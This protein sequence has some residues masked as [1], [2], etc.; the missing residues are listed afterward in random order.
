M[1]GMHGPTAMSSWQHLQQKIC[2]LNCHAPGIHVGV[3]NS[4][5]IDELDYSDDE[6]VIEEDEQERAYKLMTRRI[7]RQQEKDKLARYA[8]I[9]PAH[10]PHVLYI[11]SYMTPGMGSKHCR[12]TWTTMCCLNKQ[13]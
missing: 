2:S 5:L 1:Q 3:S 12:D 6:P 9:N 4:D 13:W 7:A 11:I 10:V 8:R